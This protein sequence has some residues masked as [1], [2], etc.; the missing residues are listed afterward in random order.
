MFMAISIG[1]YGNY[2]QTVLVLSDFFAGSSSSR[3]VILTYGNMEV[4]IYQNGSGSATISVSGTFVSGVQIKMLC[5]LKSWH[6]IAIARML[7]SPQ[8]AP[9]NVMG[10]HIL[11][12]LRSESCKTTDNY[13]R[14]FAHSCQ[15]VKNVGGKTWA[16]S[17]PGL[18]RCYSSLYRRS[19]VPQNPHSELRPNRYRR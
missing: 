4:S 19:A 5:F 11:Q 17:F 8:A 3:R 9:S 6:D 7:H 1:N 14:L 13:H 15:S 2:Q 10:I 18:H 16:S 12:N